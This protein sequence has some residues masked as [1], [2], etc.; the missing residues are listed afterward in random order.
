MSASFTIAAIPQGS[1]HKYWKSA[2]SGA[3]KAVRDLLAQGVTVEFLWKAPLREDDRQE[4][5]K[6]FEGVLRRGVHG[7][8]LAPFDSTTM[9]ALVEKAAAENIPTVIIDSALDSHKILSFIATDNLKAGAL[10]ADRMAEVLNGK[11][12]VLLLRYQEGSASTEEREEG[13]RSRLRRFPQIEVIVSDQFAGATR[14]TAKTA[15][16]AMITRY[17][18]QLAGVF[19]PNESSTAGTVMAL[20]GLDMSS[21]VAHVGFDTSDLYLDMLQAKRIQGLVVQDPFRM[22]EL[23]VKTLVDHLLGKS[24]SKHIDTGAT[25]VTAANMDSPEIARLLQHSL[26]LK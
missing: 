20:A 23:A 14:V 15:A 3:E 13:F 4:Q 12:K 16:E 10:A 9:V 2:Q 25:M 26:V 1:L 21:R 6:I 8:V 18:G 5:S 17:A 11:G 24:V 19:T 7:V 22:G